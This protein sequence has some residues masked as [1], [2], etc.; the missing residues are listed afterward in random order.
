[1][2]TRPPRSTHADPDTFAARWDRS[3]AKG[4]EHD[5][6]PHERAT[7]TLIVIASIAAIVAAW[8]FTMQ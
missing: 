6:T 2:T 4:I 3:A 5:E 7:G 8:L 1:M